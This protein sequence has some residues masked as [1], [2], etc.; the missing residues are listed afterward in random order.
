MIVEMFGSYRCDHY[1]PSTA[2]S[3]SGISHA[4]EKILSLKRH[5]FWWSSLHPR[6]CCR[7]PVCFTMLFCNDVSIICVVQATC[8]TVVALVVAL[9]IFKRIVA[10]LISRDRS[11]RHAAVLVLGDVGRSPRMQY[12][13]WS[14]SQL[15]SL[16]DAQRDGKKFH[17]SLVGYRGEKCIPRVHD[18]PAITLHRFSPLVKPFAKLPFIIWA[19]IKV[20]GQIVHLLYMLVIGIPT[21]EVLLVQT[22]PAIP[23]LVVAIVASLICGTR[24]VVDWH[25]FGYTIL[26]INL[27]SAT[28]PFV[29][30]A[31]LYEKFFS[32]FS[33]GNLCVTNAMKSWLLQN[34]GVNAAV[35]HDQP[36]DFFHRT[37]V[38]EVHRLFTKFE[39][40]PKSKLKRALFASDN[41]LPQ[42]TLLTTVDKTTG[43]PVL[44]TDRPAL[45]VSSTSWTEDEDFG[46]LLDA[47][48]AL[49]SR[50]ASEERTT[51]N[52]DGLR[53]PRVVV[54]VTGKGPQKAM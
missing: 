20:V 45:I 10:P 17:V 51:T 24:L 38:D 27:R 18:N 15:N 25:N 36:P 2:Q 26:Q 13:A 54:V 14:I 50:V 46:I 44:R 33:H 12:H 43:C 6:G 22:P 8:A 4:Q 37:S 34:W 52:G 9:A 48:V 49:D 40:D 5:I 35:L 30:I 53:F 39:A 19:P 11:T 29:R 31:T 7:R 3:L 21:P 23:S 41:T 16:P 47:I 42:D 28:H 32:K 1:V